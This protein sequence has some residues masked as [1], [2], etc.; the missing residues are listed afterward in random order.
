V[1]PASVYRSALLMMIPR[2]SRGVVEALIDELS[3]HSRACLQKL[4]DA[5]ATISTLQKEVSFYQSQY[6]Q[7]VDIVEGR[8]EK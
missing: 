4:E 5:E 3:A 7:L 8:T 2:K 6:S 1:I